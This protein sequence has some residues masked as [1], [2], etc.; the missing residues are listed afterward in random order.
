MFVVFLIKLSSAGELVFETTTSQ[1]P[2]IHTHQSRHERTFSA[3]PAASLDMDEEEMFIDLLRTKDSAV[4]FEGSDNE[5]LV[6]MA[7]QDNDIDETEQDEVDGDT[8]L[9]ME[10]IEALVKQKQKSNKVCD[11][12]SGIR[13]M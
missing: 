3:K 5:D 2:P 9:T 4:S 7:D 1:Q 10:E 13:V 6:A 8:R 12:Y 11:I